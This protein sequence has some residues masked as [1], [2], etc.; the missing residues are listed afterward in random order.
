MSSSNKTFLY[1]FLHCSTYIGV[2]GVASVL[3]VIS[4]ITLDSIGPVTEL[5]I[6]TLASMY[7]APLVI[8][9]T[10]YYSRKK[11]SY[12]SVFLEHLRQTWLL[13]PI[14]IYFVLGV[15]HMWNNSNYSGEPG[16][17]FAFIVAYILALS[18][19]LNIVVLF[20][21]NFGVKE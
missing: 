6:F 12:R 2:V 18:V 14:L 19:V 7:C 1:S 5:F 21:T 4:I 3:T 15:V 11:Y 8:Y 20:Y 16:K 17:V 10:R 13:Y 9:L